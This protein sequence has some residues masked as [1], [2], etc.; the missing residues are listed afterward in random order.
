MHYIELLRKPI[1]EKNEKAKE[2][3]KA[4]VK[5]AITT[6]IRKIKI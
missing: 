2:Y 4:N 6:E 3:K 1:W 5:G